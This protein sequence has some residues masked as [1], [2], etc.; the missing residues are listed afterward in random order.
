MAY[1]TLSL[2]E[3]DR[4]NDRIVKAKAIATMVGAA[5]FSTSESPHCLANTMWAITD[6]LDEANQIINRKDD[7]SPPETLQPE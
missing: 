2:D 5:R 3:V 4:F 6:L 7:S 1:T